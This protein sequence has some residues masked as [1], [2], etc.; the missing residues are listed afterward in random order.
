MTIQT[1][2]QS[3]ELISDLPDGAHGD[4]GPQ[5][6]GW[7]EWIKDTWHSIRLGATLG[8]AHL[9]ALSISAIAL[10][11][12]GLRWVAS[13]ASPELRPAEVRLPV[14][15]FCAVLVPVA[16]ARLAYVLINRNARDQ[17]VVIRLPSGLD[18]IVFERVRSSWRYELQRVCWSLSRAQSFAALWGLVTTLTLV[19]AAV[20]LLPPLHPTGAAL[21]PYAALAEAVVAAAGTR[22]LL[23]FARICVR[24]SNDD[25]SKRMFAEALQALILSVIATAGVVLLGRAVGLDFPSPQVEE[26][27]DVLPIFGLGAAVAILGAPAFELLQRRLGGVL[28]AE[29]RSGKDSIHLGVLGGIS[30]VDI[31]RLGEEGIESL[32]GLV[33]T[34]VSRVFL[35]TRFSL[36]RIC[37]WM[38][39]GLLVVRIGP[40]A[41][42][43]VTARAGLMGARELVAAWAA[44]KGERAPAVVTVVRKALHLDND[45][46]A[47]LLIDGIAGDPR[48]ELVYAFGRTVVVP[49][50]LHG[51]NNPRFTIEES[52]AE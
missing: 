15:M 3:T 13:G 37:D 32:E 48:V 12:D 4:D 52:V 19:T 40:D 35:N 24:T 27:G 50:E 30:G 26:A 47:A 5:R 2:G 7:S 36:Q 23:D 9:A 20:F 25:A 11:P 44:G 6:S 46:E 22:F 28:Q 38:D 49:P 29:G 33:N 45:Q 8:A 34:P 39:R 31:E 21:S 16:L 41:A 51:W 17:P 42:A 10:L 1:L 43:E 14:L 18:P